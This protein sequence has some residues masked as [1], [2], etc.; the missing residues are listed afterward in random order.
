MAKIAFSKLNLKLPSVKTIKWEDQDI[1]VIQYLPVEEKTQ[2][3]ERVLSNSVD[4]NGYYNITKIN[5]NLDLELV[6]TY[7]NISFTEKQKEDLMKLYDKIKGSGL[8]SLVKEAVPPEELN[9]LV[10][11]VWGMIENIY[12]YNRSALGIMKMVAADYSNLNFETTEIQEALQ[13]PENV[14]FLKEVLDKM[15]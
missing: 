1:E 14:G 5:F 4:D 11:T 15:G 13:N 2:F 8:L 3:F 10:D 7:T 12:E 9:E 6:F